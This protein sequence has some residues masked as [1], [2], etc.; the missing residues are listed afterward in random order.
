MIANN[1]ARYFYGIHAPTNDQ[2][3]AA[4]Y[5][6][7]LSRRENYF[8]YPFSSDSTFDTEFVSKVMLDLK[9][10]KAPDINGFTA[11]HILRSHPILPVILSKLFQLILLHKLVPTC[12]GYSC[13][14]PLPKSSDCISK[15]MKCEDFRGIAISP[16]ISKLFEY[17]FIEKFD[18][19]LSS[20]KTIWFKKRDGMQ[21]HN[22]HCQLSRRALY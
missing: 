14:V 4:L 17:C 19:F 1:F 8:G 6:E 13:I 9:C 20:S 16:I 12:F 21:P 22:L 18:E 5:N 10:E 3:A 11:E 2:R 7:Y 15:T